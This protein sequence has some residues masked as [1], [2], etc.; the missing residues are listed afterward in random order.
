[1]DPQNYAVERLKR[2]ILCLGHNRIIQKTDNEHAI[3]FVLR[4]TFKALRIEGME[5]TQES[6]P[7]AYDSSSTGCTEVACRTIGGMVSTL[8]ACLESRLRK[9]VPVAHCSFASFVARAAWLRAIKQEQSDGITAYQR[10]RS[11]TF[12]ISSGEAP[13]CDGV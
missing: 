6:H 13:L 5:S 4:N 12:S 8:R 2:D 7:A 11:G 9:Q 10:L 1:M 3:L